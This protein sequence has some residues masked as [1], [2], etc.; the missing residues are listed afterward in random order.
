MS[1]AIVV[2]NI[3]IL[4]PSPGDS[5]GWGAEA[6]EFAVE[7]AEVLN[8]ILA[9]TDI[10]ST[11][12]DIANNTTV[13]TDILGLNFN[14]GLVRAAYQIPYAVY[15]VTDS[16]PSGHAEVGEIQAVYDNAAASG[17]KWTWSVEFTGDSG[18]TFFITDSGQIQYKS[19]NITGA[20]YAG[21][22][23]FRANTIPQ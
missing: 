7:V 22:I 8:N 16:N 2:N 18:I 13:F 14:T 21:T 15:R 23:N 20:N 9:P 19:T 4:Y 6:T 12:F 11:S 10:T 17:S 3:P 5:P 1:V